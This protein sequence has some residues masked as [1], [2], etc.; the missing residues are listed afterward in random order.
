MASSGIVVDGVV[1]ENHE[2]SNAGTGLT[3]GGPRNPLICALCHD[4][5]SDPCLLACY[6]TFCS[7]CLRGPHLDSKLSC[8]VCG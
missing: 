5:Y 1:N 4:Y 2:T 3:G 6:H 7:R 8:P